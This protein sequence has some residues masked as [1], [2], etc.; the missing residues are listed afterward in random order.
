MNLLA[1]MVCVG[2]L[3]EMN[4]VDS[5]LFGLHAVTGKRDP[6]AYRRLDKPNFHCFSCCFF[7]FTCESS[8]GPRGTVSL[9]PSN[10]NS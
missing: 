7:I 3:E 4:T 5:S 10:I 2:G 6:F 9:A 8:D 1:L